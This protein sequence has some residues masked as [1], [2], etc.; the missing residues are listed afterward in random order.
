MCQYDNIHV[1]TK[2]KLHYLREEY[3]KWTAV[4]NTYLIISSYTH[5]YGFKHSLKT[6]ENWVT[7]LCPL[8]C[9]KLDVAKNNSAV[10]PILFWEFQLVF[11]LNSNN[12][13]LLW[14][15]YY[16]FELVSVHN[17]FHGHLYYEAIDCKKEET[18]LRSF[19]L[20]LILRKR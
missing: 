7:I 10:I 6:C 2:R 8:H 11:F 3:R 19:L 20:I 1:F 18:S 15:F 5:N 16:E 9:H 14:T 13:N 17:C 4:T 12:C